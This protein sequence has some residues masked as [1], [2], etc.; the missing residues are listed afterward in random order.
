MRWAKWTWIFSLRLL[1]AW[2]HI[3]IF[4]STNCA[5]PQKNKRI[6]NRVTYIIYYYK[7]FYLQ[8]TVFRFDLYKSFI[9]PKTKGR[10]GNQCFEAMWVGTGTILFLAKHHPSLLGVKSGALHPGVRDVS[11][12]CTP[13]NEKPP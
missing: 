4:K 3:E 5:R 6:Q 8:R 7:T 9:N 1:I 12:C 13:C 10:F 2:I 11:T